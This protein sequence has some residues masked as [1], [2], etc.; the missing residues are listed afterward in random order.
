MMISDVIATP[1]QYAMRASCISPGKDI[2]FK[3]PSAQEEMRP[4][5]ATMWELRSGA[6][7]L[8]PGRGR[9]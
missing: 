4:Y 7:F 6:S 9:P 8:Q 2:L 3:M 1:S 5:L